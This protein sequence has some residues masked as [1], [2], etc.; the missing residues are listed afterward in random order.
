MEKL[1]QRKDLRLKEYDYTAGWY[2]VTIC[3]VDRKCIFG[4]VVGGDA[5]IAPQMGTINIWENG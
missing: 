2:F 5:H 1:P 3:T 4:H